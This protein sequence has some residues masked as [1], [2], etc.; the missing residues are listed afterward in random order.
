MNQIGLTKKQLGCLQFIEGYVAEHDGVSPS[1]E[2]IMHALGL[3][4]KS[5]VHRL[6]KSLDE[7]GMIRRLPDRARSIM[8][9]STLPIGGVFVELGDELMRRLSEKSQWRG[10]TPRAFARS[11]LIAQLLD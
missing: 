7:R 11:C 3:H 5:G 2:E 10:M 8:P 1:Y 9:I 6:I 4:S